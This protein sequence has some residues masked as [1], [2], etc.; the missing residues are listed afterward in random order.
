MSDWER[1]KLEARVTRDAVCN[2]A[3]WYE[4]NYGTRITDEQIE[5]FLWTQPPEPVGPDPEARR[6]RELEWEMDHEARAEYIPYNR[7]S[8]EPSD[9]PEGDS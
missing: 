8:M 6:E 5:K 9:D 4:N 1:S 3:S 2:F 7:D